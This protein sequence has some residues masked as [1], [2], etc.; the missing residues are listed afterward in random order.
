MLLRSNSWGHLLRFLTIRKLLVLLNTKYCLWSFYHNFYPL[1]ATKDSG[2]SSASLSLT[3]SGRMSGG[4]KIS[5]DLS[6]QTKLIK[7]ILLICDIYKIRSIWTFQVKEM[8]YQSFRRGGWLSMMKRYSPERNDQFQFF[9]ATCNMSFKMLA[10]YPLK[11][12]SFTWSVRQFE[13]FVTLNIKLYLFQN[14]KIWANW[15]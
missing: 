3:E 4:Q 12:D 10:L 7:L 8:C 14:H 1:P 5:L 2:S 13:T 11:N 9:V 6:A 15:I